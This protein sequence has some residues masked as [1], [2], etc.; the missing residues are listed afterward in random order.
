MACE[1]FLTALGDTDFELKIRKREPRTMDD[2]LMSAQ[3]LEAIKMAADSSAAGRQRFTR[4]VAEQQPRHTTDLEMR[5]DLLERALQGMCTA[6]QPSEL[7]LVD[8]IKATGPATRTV[9]KHDASVQSST[10]FSKRLEETEAACQ[11]AEQ[12][13]EQLKKDNDALNKRVGRLQHLQQ[14]RMLPSNVTQPE[15]TRQEANISYSATK[16]QQ[17]SRSPHGHIARNC[18]RRRWQQ[19]EEQGCC[20]QAEFWFIQVC[21]S[22]IRRSARV[23]SCGGGIFE[24]ADQPA[25][26]RVSA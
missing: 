16:G 9:G 14:L 1:A 8:P 12:L 26:L 19:A 13:V 10:E 5:M 17:N 7:A 4:Q 11:A 3:R 20:S 23:S 18:C 22:G 6:G 25:V 24:Y 15:N 2:A 21:Q